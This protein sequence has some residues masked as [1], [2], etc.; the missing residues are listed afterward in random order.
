MKKSLFAMLA[1]GA[2][3][4]TTYA[5]CVSGATAYCSSVE[6]TRIHISDTG[7][8]RVKTNGDQTILDCTSA[9]SNTYLQLPNTNATNALYSFFLTAKTTKSK[10]TIRVENGSAGCMIKYAY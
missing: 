5:G 7:V 6:I 9:G 3:N 2:L 10:V 8:I 1:L 4:I